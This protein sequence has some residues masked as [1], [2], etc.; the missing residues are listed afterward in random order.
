MNKKYLEIFIYIS[1]IILLG[2]CYIFKLSILDAISYSVTISLFLFTFYSKWLWKYNPLE[3]T[4]RLKKKYV[5][6]IDY[7]Y[8]GQTR[9]KIVDVNIKQDLFS[10]KVTMKSDESFSKSVIANI[11]QEQDVWYLTYTYINEPSQKN[12]KKSKIHNGTCKLNLNDIKKING[13]YFT[14]RLSCGDIVFIG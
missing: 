14:D 3:K 7:Q 6:R 1:F 12:R 2:L 11:Y 13:E 10:V 9:N 5:A 4:P 8:G